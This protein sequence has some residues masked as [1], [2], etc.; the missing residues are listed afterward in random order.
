MNK[1]LILPSNSDL[2][3]GDQALIWN[4]IEIANNSGFNGDFYML[5]NKADHAHQSKKKGIKIIEPILKHPS[6]KYDNLNNQKYSAKLIFKWGWVSF[7]DLL[8]SLLLLFR[9]TRFLGEYLL[10]N[11]EKETLTIFKE[12][13]YCF[14]KGGGFIH[15]QGKITDNYTIY[16][17]LFHLMLARSL[18]KSIVVM[19][20]SIGPLKGYVVKK[21]VKHVLNDCK[22]VTIRESISEQCMNSLNIKCKQFPD[23]G[24]YLKKNKNN[25]EEIDQLKR[26]FPD[27]QLVGITVRPYRFPETKN[28]A[29]K[30]ENY[31]SSMVKFS[32]WLFSKNLIPV[33]IEHTLSDKEHE[34][35]IRCILEIT[36][37]LEKDTFKIISNTDFTCND[38]KAIYSNLDFLIGTRFHSVIFSLSENIP[39]IAITYGGNKGMGIMQDLNL[40]Q[41]AI[42]MA[43][44][45][46]EKIVLLFLELSKNRIEIKNH[47]VIKNY[48]LNR[49][50]I[51]FTELLR[52]YKSLN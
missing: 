5:A 1:Y 48:E 42:P 25:Y 18:K 52:E 31:T 13:D 49:K 3:R 15:S 11:K 39:S 12:C 23:L 8:K 44:F 14:V 4:T 50:Y 7:F 19:P 37:Q 17:S 41:Y 32:K 21:L 43:E 26:H 35:D 24:F 51:E 29:E 20:N 22:L 36:D 10:T 28:P 27:R 45:S 47:L 2:N 40:G 33:F 34:S 16:Y 9:F 30:Y 6:R 46:Y 38:L